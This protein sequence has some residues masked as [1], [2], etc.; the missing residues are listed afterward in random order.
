MHFRK[1][2]GVTKVRSIK[3]QGWHFQYLF[4]QSGDQWSCLC[5]ASDNKGWNEEQKVAILAKSASHTT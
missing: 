5:I 3:V 1:E 2:E 4:G